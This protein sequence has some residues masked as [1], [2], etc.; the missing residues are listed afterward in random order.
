MLLHLSIYWQAVG[1]LIHVTDAVSN[2]TDGIAF[3]RVFCW[4][5]T[6]NLLK[7]CPAIFCR[8]MTGI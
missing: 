8:W 6:L 3:I 2:D 4:K 1:M 5:N 7:P